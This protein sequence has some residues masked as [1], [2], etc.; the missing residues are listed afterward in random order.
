MYS[1]FAVRKEFGDAGKEWANHVDI[2]G[3]QRLN[4]LTVQPGSIEAGLVCCTLSHHY[5][6]QPPHFN[7]LRVSYSG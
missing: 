7:L 5:H 2:A 6:D 4:V 3:C 1:S